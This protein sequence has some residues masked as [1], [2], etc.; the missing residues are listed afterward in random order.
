MDHLDLGALLAGRLADLEDEDRAFCHQVIELLVEVLG[1]HLV[2]QAQ[3]LS[4]QGSLVL[5][6]GQ[7]PWGACPVDHPALDLLDWLQVEEREVLVAQEAVLVGQAPEASAV[8]AVVVVALALAA[9]VAVVVVAVPVAWVVA[10][11]VEEVFVVAEPEREAEQEVVV[12]LLV[13]VQLEQRIQEQRQPP[14][15]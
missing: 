2:L 7:D 14:S 3:V 10:V 11:A 5:L 4:F 13:Q 6:A 15:R 9:W 8:A 12:A 1:D